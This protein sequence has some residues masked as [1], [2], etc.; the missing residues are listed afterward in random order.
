[1]ILETSHF[2]FILHYNS[3]RKEFQDDKAE[4]S[5]LEEEIIRRKQVL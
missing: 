3:L 2:H 5:K 4:E 1:M